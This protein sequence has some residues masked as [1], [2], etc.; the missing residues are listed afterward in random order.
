MTNIA[1]TIG[2]V[3]M[4]AVRLPRPT[5]D[6]EIGFRKYAETEFGKDSA[7]AY[8]CLIHNRPINLR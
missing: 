7:Y 8:D 6:R 1:E 3:M 5:N 2:R 4:T